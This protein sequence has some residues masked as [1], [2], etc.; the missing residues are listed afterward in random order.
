[1]PGWKLPHVGGFDIAGEVVDIGP[2][3]A[4]DK[5]GLEAM[6]KARVFGPSARGR[7]D[8]VGIARPGGFAEYVALPVECLGK[9]PPAYSW[10]EAAAYPCCHIT[11]YYGLALHAKV[12]PGETV[13]VHGGS[14]GAGA[15]A[16]QVA[17]LVGANVI[18]TVGSDEKA[19]K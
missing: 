8:I 5:I 16:C 19:A 9:K 1:M 12:R 17:K 3:V 18:T 15:A 6:I 14:S 7:L 10:E 13:L 4:K 2:G 11:A